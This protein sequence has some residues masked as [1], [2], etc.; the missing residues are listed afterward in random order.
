MLIQLIFAQKRTPPTQRPRYASVVMKTTFGT[1][2]TGQRAGQERKPIPEAASTISSKKLKTA[3]AMPV[4]RIDNGHRDIRW[5]PP[6]LYDA[7]VARPVAK[8]EAR[9]NPKAQA[10]LDD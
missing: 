7:M 8:S 3:P 4:K 6:R 10:A 9:E 2:S 5:I 1:S